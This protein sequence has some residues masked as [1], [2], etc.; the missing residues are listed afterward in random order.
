MVAEC[1]RKLQKVAGVTEQ[2]PYEMPWARASA[3]GIEITRPANPLRPWRLGDS[4]A[5]IVFTW[6][7]YLTRLLRI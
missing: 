4:N 5:E 1:C 3:V 7:R 6:S 2:L